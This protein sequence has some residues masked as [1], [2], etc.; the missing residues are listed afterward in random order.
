MRFVPTAVPPVTIVELEPFRDER[1]WFARAFCA[2]E[3][4]DAGLTPVTAQTNLSH[5]VEAGTVRGLHW[6]AA[7]AEEA[8]LVRCVRG[9]IYDVAVDVR[10]GSPTYLQ[11]VGVELTADDGRALHVP[12]GFAHGFQ[13]LEDDT[14]VIYQ[15]GE[16]Y[17]P[18]AERGLR[19]DDPAI[20]ITWPRAV[21]SIS[22][23]DA[24]WALLGD[25]SS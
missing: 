21:T 8:K 14:L 12:Q 3:F 20:G 13:T 23:K 1:G 11:W 25:A 7:P 5:N 9:A 4:A 24:S 18:G 2:R 10:E 22:D 19:H 17:T 16:F 6:Q 15:V